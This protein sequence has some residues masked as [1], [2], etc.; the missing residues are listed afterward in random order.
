MNAIA[1]KP[2]LA[3][4]KQSLRAA[5]KKSAKSGLRSPADRGESRAEDA[6]VKQ[7]A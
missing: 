4:D 3:E 2:S 5:D 6:P 7:D 1:E